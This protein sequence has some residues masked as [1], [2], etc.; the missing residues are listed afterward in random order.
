[1]MQLKVSSP[2]GSLYLLS[3][4]G[5]LTALSF[6]KKDVPLTTEA[7]ADFVLKRAKSQLEEYFAG[8]RQDFDLP[9]AFSGTDFQVKVWK[10]LT[11]I[12]FGQTISYKELAKKIH[13]PLAVRA[14]GSANGKNPFCVIVPCHRVI[15]HNGSLGGYSGGL[16]KKEKLLALENA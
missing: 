1:M 5:K 15:S 14:V 6:D 3:Q 12:P 13:R 7:K 2:L 10:A 8:E 4:E 16:E 9:L 11:T